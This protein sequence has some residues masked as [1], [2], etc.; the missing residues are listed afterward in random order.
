MPTTLKFLLYVTAASAILLWP[1]FYQAQPAAQQPEAHHHQ[2][3]RWVTETMVELDKAAEA[4]S[5]PRGAEYEVCARR[6]RDDYSDDP[7]QA[8]GWVRTLCRY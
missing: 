4:G 1:A 7:E 5:E 3:Q 2:I 8:Y 6:V